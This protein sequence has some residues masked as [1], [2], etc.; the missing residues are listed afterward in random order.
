[1]F[2]YTLVCFLVVREQ[3]KLA[4][5]LSQYLFIVFYYMLIQRVIK[6]KIKR[7][8]GRLCKCYFK[9]A[10]LERGT[11]YI[12]SSVM[13]ILN[14]K[15]WSSSLEASNWIQLNKKIGLGLAFKLRHGYASFSSMSQR[16]VKS[17]IRNPDLSHDSI[18]PFP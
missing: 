8:K 16:T 7:E 5:W 14:L 9:K 10:N 4:E 1:M 6:I 11:P 13:I 2:D 3:V 12:V 17:F 18:T 15:K